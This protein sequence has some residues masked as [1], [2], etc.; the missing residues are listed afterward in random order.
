MTW[1]EGVM[2]A[3]PDQ[4]DIT[5]SQCRWI[6][7]LGQP[8]PQQRELPWLPLALPAFTGQGGQGS[9]VPFAMLGCLVAFLFRARSLP[10]P[11]PGG[12]FTG[13]DAQTQ[14]TGCSSLELLGHLS[15]LSPLW[16]S[17]FSLSSEIT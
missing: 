9:E 10:L 7:V 11:P 15:I 3:A 6:P 16:A 8:Q 5:V 4:E 17:T 12:D 2:P 14:G 1:G 13:S